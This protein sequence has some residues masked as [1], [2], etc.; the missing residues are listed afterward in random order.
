MD[1]QEVASEK[2]QENESKDTH[3]SCQKNI[4]MEKSIS[5]TS[6]TSVFIFSLSYQ[7]LL[8]PNSNDLK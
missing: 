5:T 3:I 8:N 7:D 1:V 4:F 2:L 6:I